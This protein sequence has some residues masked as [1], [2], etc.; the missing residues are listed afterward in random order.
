MLNDKFKYAA[1]KLAGNYNNMVGIG[2]KGVLVCADDGNATWFKSVEAIT[3]R[4]VGSK[5]LA[6]DGGPQQFG[7]VQGRSPGAGHDGV[8]HARR[9]A[10]T[11][12]RR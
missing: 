10:H 6:I 8:E 1:K 4:G 12:R 3:W 7:A 9:H 11:S 5:T 2:A